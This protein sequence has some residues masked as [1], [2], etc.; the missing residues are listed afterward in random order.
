VSFS[1]FYLLSDLR[2]K[3]KGNLRASQFSFFPLSRPVPCFPFRD[4]CRT[5]DGAAG[6]LCSDGFPL[7]LN[8]WSRPFVLPPLLSRSGRRL[9]EEDPSDCSPFFFLG[10]RCPRALSVSSSSTSPGRSQRDRANDHRGSSSI[11]LRIR[12]GQRFF[13]FS[14]QPVRSIPPRMR[15]RDRR[16]PVFLS[17]GLPVLSLPFQGRGEWTATDP[18]GD[19]ALFF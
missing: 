17:I 7:F 12:T 4:R 9:G 3:L 2:T 6:Y 11:L 13:I 5:K 19:G 10:H 18:L 16:N 15:S 14:F 1:P 8:Y